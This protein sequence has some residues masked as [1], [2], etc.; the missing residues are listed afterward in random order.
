MQTRVEIVAGQTHLPPAPPASSTV[1]LLGESVGEALKELA[2]TR[3][4]N[5]TAQDGETVHQKI[6]RRLVVELHPREL[7]SVRIT[8]VKQAGELRIEIVPTTDKANDLLASHRD[9][10]AHTIR[11]A[12]SVVGEITVRMSHDGG[13]GSNFQP[14][15]NPAS[16]WNGGNGT[17]GERSGDARHP[18]PDS[19]QGGQYRQDSENRPESERPS[20]NGVYL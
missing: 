1:Q 11:H 10:L 3:F 13:V 6:S 17:G 7:G 18:G 2:N 5:E 4:S 9:A 20:R 8:L 14:G 12:G 19:S 16:N 15:Q